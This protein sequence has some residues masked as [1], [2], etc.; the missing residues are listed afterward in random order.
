MTSPATD[1]ATQPTAGTT[2]DVADGVTTG[3]TGQPWRATV[4]PW[5]DIYPWAGAVDGRPVR[6]F[7]AAD[8]RWHV[9]ADETAVRQTR[10]DGTP[11]IETRLRVPD[12]DAVQRVWS[13]ADGGGL[14]IIEIENESSRPFAVAFSG[15]GIVTERPTADVPIQGID[16]PADAIVLPVGHRSTVRVAIPHTSTSGTP[17]R[18]VR[19]APASAVANGWVA[20]CEQASRLAL[21]DLSLVEA[22]VSARCDLLLEGP[23]EPGSDALGFLFDVAHLTRLGDG[24]EAWLPE[25]VDPVA[26]VAR[27]VDPRVDDVLVGLERL[28]LRAGD[29]RAAKDLSKLAARRRADAVAVQAPIDDRI[30]ARTAA[31]AVIARTALELATESRGAYLDRIER[32]LVSNGDILPG[33]IPTA[34][35]GANFEV[36]GLPTS[37]RSSIGY[38]VRWHGDRPAV[39]WEQSGDAVTLSA[40]ALDAAWSTS[41]RSGEALWKSQAVT[42]GSDPDVTTRRPQPGDDSVSFG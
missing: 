1:E 26:E 12:G 23:A 14:T 2:H 3:V 31:S 40:S 6:W 39:L 21:P 8:D 13:V 4:T 38:A 29:G 17:E 15:G 35:L 16:L 34:W 10:V 5:G 27:S 9:P 33:G 20:V 28:A 22:V 30:R 36:H 25:I 24:A 19:A 42:S 32:T 37:A 7:V 18:L 41:D 11:V